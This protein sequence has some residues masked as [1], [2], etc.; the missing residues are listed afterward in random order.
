[1]VVDEDYE[2]CGFAAE[3]SAIVADE[4]FD[5]LDAPIKRVATPVVPIPYAPV[6][7]D[8]VLPDENKIVRAVR[9][10]LPRG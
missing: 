4:V 5:Y 8:Y 6:L 1:V 10:I 9:E 7:E 2:R 3:V